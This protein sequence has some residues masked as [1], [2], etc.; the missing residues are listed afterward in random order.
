MTDSASK[1]QRRLAAILAADVVGYSAIMGRDEEGTRAQVKALQQ[2]I[3]GPALQRHQGRLVKT[4]GDGFLVEFASPVEAV[5]CALAIQQGLASGPLQLRIGINLGDVIIEPDGD[6]YGE[7][8]NVAARLEALCEPGSILISGKVYDEAEGKVE[9]TFESRGEQPVKNIAKPVR[10][11]ALPGPGTR[12]PT[13]QLKPLRLPDHPSIA[14]LAFA[15]M[16]GSPEDE[17]FSDGI[18][19]DLI[20]ALARVRWLFVIARNSS[21]VF[22]GKAV[23]AK[24]AGHQLGVR[25]VVEG[26][27]R[28]AGNRV[29]ITGQLI[30]AATGAHIWAERYD[31][32]LTGIFELQDE[33]VREI[34]AAIEPA[35]LNVEIARARAKPTESL[36]AYDL[37][38]RSLPEFYAFT[39]AGFRRAEALLIEGLARDPHFA[40]AW[41][42][43]ADCTNR[44]VT[45]G[46]IDDRDK[47]A[48][49]GCQA[50]RKAVEADPQNG[51]VLA[52]SALA[53][54]SLGGSLDE[55][56][57]LAHAAIHLQ[58]NSS[59]VCSHCG[60]VFT[61][62]GTYGRALDLFEEARRLNPLDP[63]GYM[64]NN[65][66]I[67]AHL[68]S[69]HFEEAELWTRRTL[70]KWPSHPMT[71][72]SRIAALVLLGRVDE[73]R[74]VVTDLLKVQP[75]SSL[76]RSRRS[77][78]RDT[79][80]FGV[81][82]DALRQAAL[83]E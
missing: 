11:Y 18:T 48:E 55:A 51:T 5:R 37:Y 68:F 77:H 30:E 22:K 4:T 71:L 64:T 23:D 42:A 1:V 81:Y 38:L 31:R 32:D 28:R 24:K 82:I 33:I 13:G 10:V 80:M 62:N 17:Y 72:R 59:T 49:T 73:A 75:N 43:L 56:A 76:S 58:P 69:R 29:R 63:R 9:A 36:A 83:P 34:V 8:V 3:L 50:A 16:S 41:A 61:L 54:A 2:E 52:R 14:V 26:S 45:A 67:A 27:I 6:I 78:Y 74:I 35:L 79:E 12:T 7:G 25:Y 44:L 46:W 19:E 65:G 20:T 53:L 40:E 70:A 15:N 21:F 60:W 39:E 66:I 47:A 57:E